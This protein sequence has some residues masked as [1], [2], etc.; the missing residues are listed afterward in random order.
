MGSEASRNNPQDQQPLNVPLLSRPRPLA[1][2][3]LAS[4]GK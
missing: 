2:Y 4:K 3:L 1:I